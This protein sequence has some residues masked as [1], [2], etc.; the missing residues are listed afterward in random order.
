MK[1]KHNGSLDIPARHVAKQ[2][3]HP[4]SDLRR[5]GRQL[6]SSSGFFQITGGW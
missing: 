1:W 3:G 2:N 6:Q 4:V 5:S